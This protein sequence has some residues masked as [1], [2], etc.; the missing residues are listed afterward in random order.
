MASSYFD[1]KQFRIHHDRSTMKVGTDSVLIGAWAPINGATRILDIG[2]GCGLIALMAAQR[3]PLAHITGIDIDE[4]SVGQAQEN[5]NRSPFGINVDFLKTDLTTFDNGKFD[6]ILSNPPFFEENL[7]PSNPCRAR[8]RHTHGLSFELLLSSARRLL[9]P[10]G[11]FSLIIPSWSA[12]RFLTLAAAQGLFVVKRTDVVTRRTKPARRTLLCLTP[13]APTAPTTTDTLV[14][15][16]DDG[17]RSAAHT[18]L[19]QD[20]YL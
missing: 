4:S 20:F 11:Y 19:T 10:H 17:S 16:D 5:A 12:E 13:T 14:L 9:L 15:N 8:A 3:N 1:F 18:T 2:C 6:C 7:L